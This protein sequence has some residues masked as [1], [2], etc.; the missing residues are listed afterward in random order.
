MEP[1][2]VRENTAVEACVSTISQTV[3]MLPIKHYKKTEDGGTEEIK[4]SAALRVLNNP[5]P[6]QTRSDF[7]LNLTRQE[8]LTGNG[9]AVATRNGRFE[10][11]SLHIQNTVS[12]YITPDSKD[13]YYSLAGNELFDVATFVP[14]RD[15]LHVKLQTPRHPLIGETPLVAAVVAAGTGTNI[16]NHESAFFQNMSRPSGVLTTDLT[17]TADQTKALRERFKENSTAANAGGMPILTS[18]LKFQSMTMTAV[19]AQIIETYK[20]TIADVAR[21]YRVPLVLINAMDNSTFNNVEALMKYWISGG[22][23]FVLDHLEL[24]LNDLFALPAGEYLNFDTD[25][26][27][28]SDFKSR[29]EGL[30]K[31]V[32]GGLYTPNEARSKEGMG[33][34]DNGDDLYLQAQMVPIGTSAVGIAAADTIPEPEP[35]PEP[36]VTEEDKQYVINKFKGVVND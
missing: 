32:Q 10:V 19:D 28:R 8:L 23:G 7:F 6:Y 13:V 20:M 26:L 21:V 4:S 33:P 16:Q 34:K 35:E 2:D 24:V 30:T 17:L 5:N 25:Y 9:Y 36:E 27:L 1:L 15:V 18:G 14:A 31:S 3:A 22:L 12:P 29:M 11:D